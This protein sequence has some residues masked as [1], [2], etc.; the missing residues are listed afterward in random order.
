MALA[1]G[2]PVPVDEACRSGGQHRCQLGW[3]PDRGRAADDHRMA[4]VVRADAQQPAQDVRDVAAEDAA[5]CVQLVDDDEAQLLEQLE[6]F[7]VV[8]QDRRVEHVRIGDHDLT[9]GADRRADRRRRVAVVCRR[10]DMQ[11]AGCRQLPEFGDLVLAEGLGREEQQRSRGRIL[12]DGLKD[13]YRVTQR[14]S[15]GGRGHDDHVRAAVDGLDRLC[16]VGVR[17]ADA[18]ARQTGHDARVEP[19]GEV[20]EVGR[21]RRQ[22]GVMDDAAGDRW[23]VEQV[24]QDGAGVGGGVGSHVGLPLETNG[25]SKRRDSS[26]RSDRAVTGR[27]SRARPS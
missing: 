1:G 16:L 5:V 27:V 9:G 11:A 14:L 25:R 8:G 3:V 4:A 7:G 19:I 15:R 10:R 13:R 24:G 18:A 6:P 23:F 22:D 21:S 17:P 26:T 20:G 12:G 2:R